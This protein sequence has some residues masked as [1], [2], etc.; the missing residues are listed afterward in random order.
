MGRPRCGQA[1][2]IGAS[3]FAFPE[4]ACYPP[5]AAMRLGCSLLIAALAVALAGCAPSISSIN[6]RPDKYYQHK[7]TFTGRI[8]RMQFLAHE[9]LLELADTHGGRIVVRSPEPVEAETGDWVKVEGVLVPE[10]HVEDAVLYDIVAA[11]RV[12]R[13]RAPH[14]IDLM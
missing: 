7:V 10:T 4:N 13:T 5:A 12:S 1:R 8:R 6:A 11:E 2:D 14:F 3:D 9:T